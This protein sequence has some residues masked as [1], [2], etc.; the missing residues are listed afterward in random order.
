[1]PT[2]RMRFPS[3]LEPLCRIALDFRTEEL[4]IGGLFQRAAPDL[5][6][7][8]FVELVAQVLNQA[9]ELVVAWQQYSRDK[10]ATPSPYLDGTEVGFVEVVSERF[11]TRN[12]CRFESAVD[13]CSAFILCEAVWVLE[14]REVLA[15]AP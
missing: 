2:D 12:V 3:W 6:D 8:E 13:A 11:Q 10:R 7:P 14:R 1:M 9:P 15:G 4:S 5:T